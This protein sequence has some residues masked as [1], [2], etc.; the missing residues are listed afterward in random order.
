MA[1]NANGQGPDI[2]LGIAPFGGRSEQ[3]EIQNHPPTMRDDN[4]KPM[5]GPGGLEKQKQSDNND[6]LPAK[7]DNVKADVP[8][9][10]ARRKSRAGQGWKTFIT[11]IAAVSG[12]GS[13]FTLP[14]TFTEL[15]D[16]IEFRARTGQRPGTK[17][18]DNVR[19]YLRGSW[20]A[21]TTGLLFVYSC[22]VVMALPRNPQQKEK[23]FLQQYCDSCISTL[24]E[25]NGDSQGQF[26]SYV[27]GL[28]SRSTFSTEQST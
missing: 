19:R 17:S 9:T 27:H 14:L 11:A 10:A 1:A 4:D 2:E 15:V 13:A 8:K 3:N 6:L 24:L 25:Q 26:G 23:F 28:F 16:P 5:N 18:K 21:F 12:A 7:P 22:Q 20:L